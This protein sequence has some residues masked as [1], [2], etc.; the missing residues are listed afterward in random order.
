[1]KDMSGSLRKNDRKQQPNHP[2]IKG[3]CSIDG[4]EFWISGWKKEGDTG[5]WYSLS[6]QPKEQQAAPKPVPAGSIEDMDT[7]LPF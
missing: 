3:S 5:P 1:M 6:F 4:R 7:D 2:D